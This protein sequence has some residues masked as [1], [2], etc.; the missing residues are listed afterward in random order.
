GAAMGTGD[1]PDALWQVAVAIGNTRSWRE[2]LPVAQRILEIQPA[3]GDA[4]LLAGQLGMEDG[5]TACLAAFERA[6]AA[7][8]AAVPVASGLAA[9]F[10]EA[11]GQSEAAASYRKRADEYRIAEEA[12]AV[13]RNRVCASDTFSPACCPNEIT[14]A[15]QRVVEHHGSHVRAAYLLRKQVPGGDEK[16]VYI[17]GIE[18]RTFLFENTARADRLMLERISKAPGLPAGVLVCVVTRINRGLL[19]K[20][21]AV[22]HA[23][24]RR[25]APPQRAA[26]AHLEAPAATK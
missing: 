25:S 13:E 12:L 9:R 21:K 24:L 1:D 8:P 16:P 15:L 5:D 10:L 7:T 4:N 18:R 19:G 14:A 17:L 3:H 26:L 6:M 11:Q 23:L 20:W 22:P 2:A